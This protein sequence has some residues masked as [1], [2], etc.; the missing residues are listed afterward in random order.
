[1]AK[2]V[3]FDVVPAWS[4]SGSPVPIAETHLN[5]FTCTLGEAARWSAENPHPF[6]TVNDLI[7]EQA[8]ELRQRPALN[9]AGD[10]HAEDGR[11]LKSGMSQVVNIY[12]G[13]KH[14]L[15]NIEYRFYLPRTPDLLTGSCSE[16]SQAFAGFD[17]RWVRNSG[18]AVL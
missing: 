1:M 18:L 3:R 13:C 17:P 14:S 7:D 10:C 2:R 16:A 9:I 12:C 4:R 15:A 6:L 5:Y 11:E 8:R